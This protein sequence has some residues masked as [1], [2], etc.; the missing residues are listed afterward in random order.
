[1]AALSG[2]RVWLTGASSGIG[3]A[4]AEEL[5]RAGARVALTARREA[6]LEEIAGRLGAGGALVAPAD[7]TDRAGLGRVVERIEKEWGGIDLAVFNAGLYVP[8]D[9]AAIKAEDY[10]ATF[11]VNY[12]GVLHGIEV[13]VP[14]MVRR[15]RGRVAAVSSLAGELPLPRS[16]AYGS[17][18][19][20]LTYLLRTLRFDLR[21]RGIGVTLIQ[22]GFVKTPMVGQNDFWM[23]GLMEVEE[24]ARV[25]AEGLARGRD[26]I[27][28]PRRL[29][30]PTKVVRRLPHAAWDRLA[31][32]TRV[33][34]G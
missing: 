11:A 32:L 34:R 29:A 2:A 5:A 19:A 7:V 1:M 33:V 31:R 30:I 6:A 24:A 13:V 23:P 22:P 21:P 26:E 4:L 28:F 20:A 17:S 14:G 8:V 9:G 25:V 16:A 10:E 15:G 18:K 3:A 12:F 27:S